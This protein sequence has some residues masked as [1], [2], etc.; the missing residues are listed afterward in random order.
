MK[1]FEPVS[2]RNLSLRNR[3][4]W[5]PMVSWLGSE[6]GFVTDAVIER[7]RRRARGGA[8]M[9]VVE[10]T[11]VIARKSPRL[12]RICDDQFIPGLRRL[13]DAVHAEGA[14][15][16]IQLIHFLRS[17]RSGYREKVEDLSVADIHQIVDD[18]AGA[19]V[20][21]RRSGFDAVELHLAHSYTLASFISLLNQRPDEYGRSLSGRMRIIG[22]IVSRCRGELGPDYCIGCR[23]NAEDFVVGGNTLKQT[24]PIARLLAE[25]GLNYISMSAGGKSEDGPWYTGYSSTRSMPPDYAPEL[26]NIYLY[27]DLR[28]VVEPYGVP[29]VVAG[30]I[31]TPDIAESLMKEGKADLIGLA[32]PLLCDPDWPR[33]HMEGRPK[34]ILKCIYCNECLDRDRRFEPVECTT[35]EKAAAKRAG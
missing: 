15:I 29:V 20:R 32:R 5:L 30:K 3:L 21:A 19:A 11:G 8:G 24:R 7:Y 13:V 34:E 14:K 16:S 28:K 10:A 6:D 31:S 33:K 17:S 12:L 9:V 26:V 18:F 1:L 27:A 2:F 35:A 23:F 4:V 22:E 25:L